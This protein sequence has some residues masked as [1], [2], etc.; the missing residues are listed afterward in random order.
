[1]LFIY[2]YIF[3]VGL[4]LGSF[5]NV[6]GLRIPN[7]ESIIHPPSHCPSC[8][9]RLS[10]AQLIP[11]FSYIF[12]KGKCKNCRTNISPIYP[13]F[14]ALTAGLFVFALYYIG[15]DS[16]L[17][18]AW[19]LISLLVIITV[20]DLNYQLIPDRILLFF[21]ILILILRIGLPLDPW[22]D[23]YAGAL[24]GFGILL[25]I[26]IVSKGGMGGGDIKLFGVLGLV[27]GIQG[28]L[29]TLMLSALLGSIV[30][31][32]L[33][34]T[35]KVKRGMPMAFG[36]FIAVAALISYFFAE[37]ILSWYLQLF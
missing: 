34:A 27:L 2:L 17:F 31:L 37:P 6:V 5:Y 11:V 15:F 8:N 3:F 1:M 20:S 23:A 7:N 12:Q 28:V 30:G 35:G 24:L 29:L 21:V 32:M 22:W 14:E 25:I 19:T 26:A 36:P 18:I 16:E 13:F 33:I 10:T 9:Q 4:I